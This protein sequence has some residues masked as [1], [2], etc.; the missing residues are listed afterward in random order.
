MS[1]FINENGNFS[2]LYGTA[3]VATAVNKEDLVPLMV[4]LSR[5]R[6][7][8]LVNNINIKIFD[9]FCQTLAPYT[10]E[11]CGA[12]E[13]WCKNSGGTYK[14]NKFLPFDAMLESHYEAKEVLSKHLPPCLVLRNPILK[15]YNNKVVLEFEFDEKVKLSL[16]RSVRDFNKIYGTKKRINRRVVLGYLKNSDF[17][18]SDKALKNLQGLVPG[19]IYFE[20]P[21][22]Y[23]YSNVDNYRLYSESMF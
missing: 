8:K 22:V 7:V 5:Y 9:I 4:E 3:I 2:A 11:T 18:F 23:Q 15:I 10:G 1:V 13:N 19:K 16:A 20:K 21:N 14:N 12:L 17:S 6:D